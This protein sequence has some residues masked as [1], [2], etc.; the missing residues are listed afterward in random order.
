MVCSR[1]LFEEPAAIYVPLKFAEMVKE[2][3]F[4]QQ[5]KKVSGSFVKR[6][7]KKNWRALPSPAHCLAQM[8][9][10]QDTVPLKYS[11][12]DIRLFPQV[13]GCRFFDMKYL[14]EVEALF[15]DCRVTK[16]QTID[17]NISGAAYV[18]FLFIGTLIFKSALK[19]FISKVLYRQAGSS[20]SC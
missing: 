2:V 9:S 15:Q 20:G 11:L 3:K 10:I 16:V 5:A 8:C 18:E 6:W 4:A 7:R 1:L 19:I 17:A 13:G 12:R 14:P